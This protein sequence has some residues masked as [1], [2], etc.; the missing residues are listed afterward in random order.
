M[1]MLGSRNDQVLVPSLVLKT[2]KTLALRLLPLIDYSMD[3]DRS[4]MKMFGFSDAEYA[5]IA[6]VPRITMHSSIKLMRVYCFYR[7]PVNRHSMD[8]Q[9]ISLKYRVP[10]STTTC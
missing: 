10:A 1:G 3:E 5:R 6:I 7:Q 2:H 4:L 9:N 8:Y